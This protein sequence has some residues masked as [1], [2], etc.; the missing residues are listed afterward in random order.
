MIDSYNKV[1]IDDQ[2]LAFN[3]QLLVE[4]VPA[5]GRVLA[6]VKAD[7]Y[8]HGMV[9]VARIF[10]AAGCNQFGVAEIGEG[11]VL[12]EA[13]CTGDIVIFLGVA[14]HE[15]GYCFTHS[16]TPVLFSHEMIRM[17]G[18]EAARRD[19]RIGVYLKFDCGMSRLGFMPDQIDEV[20]ATLK[21]YPALDL[22][23][24]MTHFPCADDRGSTQ[25][26]ASATTFRGM[27]AGAN[28]LPLVT[29]SLGNSGALLYFTEHGGEL[30]RPG[31]ALYGYYPDGSGSRPADRTT[32]LRPAMSFTSRVLQ[33]KTVGA[34][35][36]ISYGHTYIAERDMDLAV[37]P[38]GYSDGY[39]R[40]LS[41]RAQVLIGGQRA[42]LRGRVCMNLC[43]V[44]ITHIHGVQ[45]GDEVVLMGAQGD[46]LID[47]DEIGTWCDTISYEILCAVGSANQRLYVSKQ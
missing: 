22:A 2:A 31:L 19:T 46:D 17:A 41:N 20:L 34:G 30:F 25:T 42:P 39:L 40:S 12:R 3:Y 45:P 47:A 44:D 26:V 37:L 13:G 6:M 11:V 35:S 9:E 43:M 16:I 7:G 15:L 29:H 1:Y 5:G 27:V 21:Q 8:G 18:A 33:V 14:E 24:L 38:V 23:G 32:A 4:T 10:A 36:G 28:E